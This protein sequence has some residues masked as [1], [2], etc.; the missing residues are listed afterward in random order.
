MTFKCHSNTWI[1]ALSTWKKSHFR[2]IKKQ[3]LTSKWY[4]TTWIIVFLLHSNLILGWGRGRKWDRS[5]LQPQKSRFFEFTKSRFRLFQRPKISWQCHARPWNIAFSTS[6]N[7]HLGKVKRP[8][9]SSKWHANPSNIA[10]SSSPKSHFGWSRGRKWV[11][12]AWR[13]L[14]TSLSRQHQSRILGWQEAE[15]DF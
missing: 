2:F 15:N 11:P 10:F 14:E 3:K 13:P 7:S 4:S 8:K 6:P 12:S 5:A 9:M 1:V